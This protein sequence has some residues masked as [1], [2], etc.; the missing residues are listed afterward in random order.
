M[1]IKLLPQEETAVKDLTF[2][3]LIP[4][5]PGTKEG[6]RTMSS[7]CPYS[8]KDPHESSSPLEDES[9]RV[10]DIFIGLEG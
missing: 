4:I 2:F 3:F 7:Q 5:L 10:T 8:Q 1:H 9:V 6:N